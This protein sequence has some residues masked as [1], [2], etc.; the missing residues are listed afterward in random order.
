MSVCIWG[1][2]CVC[3]SSCVYV[4]VCVCVLAVVVIMAAQHQRAFEISFKS[5]VPFQ[6]GQSLAHF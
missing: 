1:C 2:V 3:V 6:Q 4:C 5:T